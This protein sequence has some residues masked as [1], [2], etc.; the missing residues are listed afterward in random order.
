MTAKGT[1]FI[2]SGPS[3]V[4]KTTV[5]GHLRKRL[6]MSSNRLMNST[7]ALHVND[8]LSGQMFTV[9]DMAHQLVQLK[10]GFKMASTVCL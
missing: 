9:I 2:I 6:I 8:I 4:G 7:K 10:E 1:L 3:G 5:E